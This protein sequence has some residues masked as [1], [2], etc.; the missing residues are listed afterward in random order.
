[1]H[2]DDGE[3]EYQEQRLRQEIAY[4]SVCSIPERESQITKG[5]C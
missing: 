3:S 4:R 2:V 1:M 5:A